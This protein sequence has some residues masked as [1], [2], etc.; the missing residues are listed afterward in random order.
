MERKRGNASNAKDTLSFVFDAF[1]CAEHPKHAHKGIFRVFVMKLKGRGCAE[2]QNT[3]TVCVRVFET[4]GRGKGHLGHPKQSGRG[5]DA[6]N[7]HTHPTGCVWVFETRGKGRGRVRHQ[8]H[9]PHRRVS[10]GVFLV[11]KMKGKGGDVPS[12]QNMVLRGV[13]WSSRRRGSA[14]HQKHTTLGMFWV[15]GAWRGQRRR[16][17]T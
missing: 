12:T 8:K 3:P 1:R 11:F 6:P 15:S 9:A 16:L 13:F 5:E 2:H 7:T 4:R 17:N 14:R 10:V